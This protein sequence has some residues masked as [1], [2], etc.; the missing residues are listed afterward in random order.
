MVSHVEC[1]SF[2][3][4][5][6]N[7]SIFP[8]PM[9]HRKRFCPSS[10]LRFPKPWPQKVCCQ[11]PSFQN[12]GSTWT[13][14]I[15]PYAPHPEPSPQADSPV[16]SVTTVSGVTDPVVGPFWRSPLSWCS[17]YACFV[18]VF[19]PFV[20]SD[21]AAPGGIDMMWQVAFSGLPSWKMI[22]LMHKCWNQH[23]TVYVAETPCLPAVSYCWDM[24]TNCLGTMAMGCDRYHHICSFLEASVL[25]D[26]CLPAFWL[27]WP[28]CLLS[29]G[30]RV[31][32]NLWNVCRARY[33]AKFWQSLLHFQSFIVLVSLRTALTK[34]TDGLQLKITLDT[35]LDKIKLV[36]D[37]FATLASLSFGVSAWNA[38]LLATRFLASWC[39]LCGRWRL[40]IWL[41][42]EKTR[43][44]ETLLDTLLMSFPPFSRHLTFCGRHI[45]TES[46]ALFH[47]SVLQS[48]ACDFTK[49]EVQHVRRCLTATTW[50]FPKLVVWMVSESERHSAFR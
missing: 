35:T 23:I 40:G 7:L 50:C 4:A 25:A 6:E 36:V 33:T 41:F 20:A 47:Y 48:W 34:Q 16:I 45:S 24:F 1:N 28:P 39:D 2:R 26:R 31:K 38:A 8:T 10:V 42:S 21:S 46:A 14:V 29:T 5:V 9:L 15:S 30:L 19:Q 18:C 49:R 11:R 43:C 12:L 44:Q 27:L 13:Q 37:G 22:A 3:P 32:R 17:W